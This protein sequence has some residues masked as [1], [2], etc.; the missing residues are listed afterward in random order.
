MV[1]EINGTDY[2]L[3]F[4]IGFIRRLNVM[5]GIERDGINIRGAVNITIPALIMG[6]VETIADYILC[7]NKNLTVKKVD[8][9]LEDVANRDDTGELFE[10]LIDEIIDA[11]KQG[12]M[13]RLPFKKAM[14][15]MEKA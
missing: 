15:G 2:P 8:T 14:E 7:A 10:K 6:D 4:D 13:T 3:N 1:I 5:R 11:V 9:Y 12:S